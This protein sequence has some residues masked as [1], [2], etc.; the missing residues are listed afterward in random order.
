MKNPKRIYHRWD[1]WECY[2]AGFYENQ[3][4]GMTDEQCKEAYRSFLSDLDLFRGALWRVTTEWKKSC[5]HYLTNEAMNRIA[6][7]GQASA[8]LH[9]GIPC[10]YRSGYFLLSEDQRKAAD[11]VALDALNQWLRWN[12]REP[13]DL[14]G[15]GVNMK[16]DQY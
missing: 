4:E 8:C 14:E 1:E 7:L 3:K 6:W 11:L 13:T 10:K 2:P 5:E 9:M 15:A 12:D 16:A